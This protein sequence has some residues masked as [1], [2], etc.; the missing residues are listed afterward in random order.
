MKVLLTGSTGQLG[1]SIIN[2]KS[3]NVDLITTNRSEL[4]LSDPASCENYVL[5]ERPDWIINCAAYTSVDK[6]EKDIDLAR[7]INS[8]APS[9][10]KLLIKL[11]GTYCIS[12]QILFLME[13]KT[14]H[15][16]LVRRQT[17]SINTDVPRH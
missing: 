1:I 13:N 15:I 16:K 5:Y 6:A 10:Q 11:M 3:K 17:L 9:L 4:D 7:S 14:I 8:Y 12:V 2:T